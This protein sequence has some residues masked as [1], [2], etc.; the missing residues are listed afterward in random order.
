MDF[1]FK[2][3]EELANRAVVYLKD[4]GKAE[5]TVGK[6]VWIWKQIDRYLHDNKIMECN[7]DA[8]LEYVR[9]KFGDRKICDLTHY[10]KSCVSQAFNLVQFMEAGEMF[11][12]IEHVQKEKPELNGAI[13]NLMSDYLL[14][15]QSKR[16]V[17]KTLKGY[18]YYLYKFQKY[19]YGHGILE[20]QRIS[21]I[22]IVSYSSHIS[23]VHP[24]AKHF[25]LGIIRGFLRYAYDEKKTNTDLSLAVPRDNYKN[26]PKLPSTYTKEETEK[27]LAVP[28]LSTSTG[29]RNYAILLLIVRLGL[30]ASDV[31]FCL[32]HSKSV[33]VFQCKSIPFLSNKK[34]SRIN[35][36]MPLILL[37]LLFFFVR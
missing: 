21:P 37:P 2:Y 22:S 6:Y 8:V 10:E 29:R 23:P 27:I 35:F 25:A 32:F 4:K 12:M 1:N 36:F 20:V 30:R 15:L 18:K 17:K 9:K 33:P 14:L 13:G 34:T 26:Q 11:E 24:G 16:L 31:R 5:T 7:K 19:L 3:L 28:D